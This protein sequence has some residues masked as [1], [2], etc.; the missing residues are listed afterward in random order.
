MKTSSSEQRLRECP[1]SG[2][3]L[4]VHVAYLCNYIAP[5]NLPVIVE[6]SRRVEKLTVLLSTAMD[7]ARQWTPQWG[8]LDVTV[9]RTWTLRQT[10]RHPSGFSEPDPVYIPWNTVAELRA[11]RPDV[12]V[13]TELGVRTLLSTVYRALGRDTL[14]LAITGLSEHTE[15]GR[16]RMRHVLRKMLLRFS[17]GVLSNGASGTRYLENLGCDPRKLFVCP[18]TAVPDTF[19]RIPA[20]RPPQAAHRLLFVGQLN[21]RKGI[22]PLV[23]ALS[24]WAHERP[25]R[26]VELDIVGTGPLKA[27]LEALP[28]PEN[29]SVRL[30]GHRGAAEIAACYAEAGIFVFPTLADEW[31]VVVNEAMAAGLPVLGSAYAQAVEELCRDGQSGWIFRPD[32]PGEMEQALDRALS[33]PAERLDGMRQAARQ[34][35]AHMTPAYAAGQIVRAIQV[36]RDRRQPT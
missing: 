11:L 20:A 15:R 12:I 8:P 23:E 2:Q 10:W 34:A 26:Q 36:L 27:Q 16:G 24:R 30:L 21:Q 9:Q 31:G 17:D 35:V 7:R 3:C 5:Y 6:L 28:R 1:G 13:T 25:D 29:L 18:Y 22:V 32:V 4:P 19:D 33:T 14:L